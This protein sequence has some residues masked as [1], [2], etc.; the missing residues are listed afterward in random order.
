MNEDL[1][2]DNSSSAGALLSMEITSSF[3]LLWTI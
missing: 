1:S 2:E 3:P